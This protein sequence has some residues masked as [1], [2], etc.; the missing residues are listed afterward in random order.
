MPRTRSSQAGFTLLET[1]IVVAI[2]GITAAVAIPQILSYLRVYRIRAAIQELTTAVQQARTR[3]I[4]KSAQW[5]VVFAVQDNATYWV[6]VEDDQSLPR[7]GARQAL[8][9]GAPDNAQSTRYRLPDSVIF[10]ADAT[11]CTP[12][13][14]LAPAFAPTDGGIRFS[15]LGMACDPGSNA[16]TCPDVGLVGGALTNLIQNAAASSIIC[17]RDTRTG[18]SRWIRIERGGRV[19]AQR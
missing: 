17:L 10:A 15:R 1:L 8:N 2:I 9:L 4:M 12:T 19:E 14:P 3:A 13:P 5:G 11:E 16:T 6:H 18:F 7:L